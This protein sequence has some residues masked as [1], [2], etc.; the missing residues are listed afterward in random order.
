VHGASC[1]RSLLP[2]LPNVSPR[3]GVVGAPSLEVGASIIIGG[4]C[5]PSLAMLPPNGRGGVDSSSSS[6]NINRMPPPPPL[7][8]MLIRL[9]SSSS[10]GSSAPSRG[11]VANLIACTIQP[12]TTR[13][14]P[15]L[16]KTHTSW[17]EWQ[18]EPPRRWHSGRP[19]MCG[20]WENV[21]LLDKH[22]ERNCFACTPPTNLSSNVRNM[23]SGE[24]AGVDL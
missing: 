1:K 23:E 5:E 17:N 7:A 24:A 16:S 15:T 18:H 14:C 19:A 8:P 6:S 12:T 9:D 11:G 20:R 22:D 13:P 3:C 4:D 21:V 2:C 10:P